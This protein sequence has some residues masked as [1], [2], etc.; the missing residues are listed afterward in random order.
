MQ[1][2]RPDRLA[3]LQQ[4]QPPVAEGNSAA[5]INQAKSAVAERVLVAVKRIR[6]LLQ[7]Y[8]AAYADFVDNGRPSGF[9]AFLAEAPRQFAELGEKMGAISHMLEFW[10]C[11]F[12]SGITGPID[13]DE[14]CA[15]LQ[16]F[17]SGF[18][19]PS[20]Q[21][22]RRNRPSHNYYD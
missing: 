3:G 18:A 19:L 10:Q 14:L 13:P 20:A 22:A 2:V 16:D 7:G 5:A 21:G 11:R 9:R 17:E 12:P 1:N 15:I 8:D 6:Q 4:L